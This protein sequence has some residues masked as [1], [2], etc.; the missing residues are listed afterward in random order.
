MDKIM[1]SEDQQLILAAV[2][3]ANTRGPKYYN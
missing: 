3:E 2:E 1:V